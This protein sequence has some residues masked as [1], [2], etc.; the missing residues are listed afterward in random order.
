MAADGEMAMIKALL[1]ARR[2]PPGAPALSLAERRD[3]MET[4][5]AMASLPDG[6]RHQPTAVGGIACE[7]I[8]PANARPGRVIL[9]L[10]GGAY[11]LGSLTTHRPLAARLAE[12]AGCEA[13]T[14]GYRLAPEHPFPAA[15][16]DGLAAYRALLD[17][18]GP[19]RVVI[20]GDSAGGGLTVATALAAKAAGL[21]QPAGL[22]LISTWVD[23]TQSS[24]TYDSKAA[25]D[26]MSTKAGLDESAAT[27]LGAADAAH[28]HA[29]PVF[30]DLS[31]LAPMLIQVGSEETL[32]GDS[33]LL[34]ARAGEARVHVRLEVW[35]EMIHVW[36][37]FGGQVAAARTAI[38]DA[39]VWIAA[40][41]DEAGR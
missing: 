37:A 12:A 8:T 21:P 3:A 36:H 14:A 24:A 38:R 9:Y 4:F 10:H 19:E 6:C 5:A 11:L 40:R 34:A 26:P 1:E 31:G 22:F 20:A 33:I 41:L 23:L 35:P 18:H 29:S 32:L 17:Q 16:D 7:R 25:H 39:G 2:P 15:V 28:P 13:V 27:Y 30:G